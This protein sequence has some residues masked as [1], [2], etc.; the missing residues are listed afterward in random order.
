MPQPT[1]YW[2]GQ[3]IPAAD[4]QENDL[5]LEMHQI[6][7]HTTP[8]QVTSIRRTPHYVFITDANLDTT[9]ERRI[10]H[11]TIVLRIT[12]KSDSYDYY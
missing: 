1:C 7:A 5:I 9:E 8:I 3:I 6:G 10:H 4:I 12:K 11:D 2:H